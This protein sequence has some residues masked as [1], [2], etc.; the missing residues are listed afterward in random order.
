MLVVGDGGLVEH[1]SNPGEDGINIHFNEN[2]A[3]LMWPTE[4]LHFLSLAE[5]AALLFQNG[6][7]DTYVPPLDA[8]RYQTAASNPKTVI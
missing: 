8:I 2:W 1:T 6:I 3:A 7:H 4:S 5:P